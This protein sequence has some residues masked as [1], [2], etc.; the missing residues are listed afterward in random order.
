MGSHEFTIRALLAVVLL[1]PVA[2]DGA[3]AQE[4]EEEEELPGFVPRLSYGVHGGIATFGSFLD[5]RVGDR[6]REVTAEAVPAAGVSLGFDPWRFTGVRTAIAWS[7]GEL[8]FKDDTGDDGTTLDQPGLGNFDAFVFTLELVQFLFDESERV[9]PY[10]MGGLSWTVWNFDE[11]T[12]VDDAVISPTG[13]GAFTR[14]GETASVGLQIRAT[15]RLNVRLEFTTARLGNPFD[16]SESLRALGGEI[17]EKPSRV[18]KR[19]LGIGIHYS[20]GG[21]EEPDDGE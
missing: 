14:L 7:P 13:K 6:E 12:F 8:K 16:G 3:T 9:A 2:A 5:Q 21:E 11:S 10:A 18:T 15:R 1:L 17:F 4:P 19:T 20:L